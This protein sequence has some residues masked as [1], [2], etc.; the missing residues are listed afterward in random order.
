MLE[1]T[2]RLQD[3]KTLIVD[4]ATL[5]TGAGTHEERDRV[6]DTAKSASILPVPIISRL[7]M[8]WMNNAAD[9]SMQLQQEYTILLQQ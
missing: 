3:A 1:Y 9:A 2:V 5:S 8:T 7:S 6:L 4:D